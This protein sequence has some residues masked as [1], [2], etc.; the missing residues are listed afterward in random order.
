MARSTA[1][2]AKK[3]EQED[4]GQMRDVSREADETTV[5]DRIKELLISY[6]VF[7]GDR[8]HVPELADQLRVSATPV[9]EAL[10]RIW[11]EGLLT[12]VPHRGFFV[13]K[14]NQAEIDDLY[15]MKH[16]NLTTAETGKVPCSQLEKPPRRSTRSLTA[17]CC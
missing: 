5:Y 9:R 13:K 3:N 4:A 11:A 8:L 7:P 1:V 6:S 12:A 15:A 14:M 10:N 17:I 2:E 16:L